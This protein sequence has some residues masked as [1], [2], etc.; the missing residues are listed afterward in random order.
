MDKPDFFAMRRQLQDLADQIGGK[1][2][3]DEW[4]TKRE[5]FFKA[6]YTVRYVRKDGEITIIDPTPS[7]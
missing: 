7:N 2:N 6:V 3:V 4:Q 5:G 1:V